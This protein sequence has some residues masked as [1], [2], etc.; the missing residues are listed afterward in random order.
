MGLEVPCP[1]S[2]LD[3]LFTFGVR[4]NLLEFLKGA[5]SSGFSRIGIGRQ[6]Q[7]EQLHCLAHWPGVSK[8]FLLHIAYPYQQTYQKHPEASARSRCPAGNALVELDLS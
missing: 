6:E 1:D 2:L 5:A 7:L 8:V 4:E 3:L